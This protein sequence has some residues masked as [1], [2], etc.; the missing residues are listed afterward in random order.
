MFWTKENWRVAGTKKRQK[1]QRKHLNLKTKASQGQ[2]KSTDLHVDVVQG[3]A[4][5]YA[6]L[7]RHRHY[8]E[9]GTCQHE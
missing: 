3:D 8:R 1:P 9:P 7:L 2:K 5:L 4:L 6:G